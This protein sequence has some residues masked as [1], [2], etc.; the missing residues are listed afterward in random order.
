MLDVDLLILG[1]GL[2]GLS[3][4]ERLAAQPL[5]PR[6]CVLEAR[7][8]YTDD[9][10]WCSWRLGRGR[11]NHLA[12]SSWSRFCVRDGTRQALVDCADTPYQMIP[13]SVFYANAMEVLAGSS[14]VSLELGTAVAAEPVPCDDGWMVSLSDGRCLSA[15]YVVDTRPP[16]RRPQS[17]LW[18]SFLGDVVATDRDVFD[19]NT[20][21]LMD[22]DEQSSDGVQFLYVLPT[23]RREALVETT[24]FGAVPLDP[25]ALRAR[26]VQGLRA[27]VDG[28]GYRVQRSEHGVL[29]MGHEPLPAAA[30]VVKASLFHGGARASTGYAFARIQSWADTCAAVLLRGDGP[31]GPAPDPWLRRVMDEV[32]LRVLRA[33]PERGG[34]L[35]TRMFD[36]ADPARVIRFLSDRGSVRD[37]LSVVGSL[38]PAPFLRATWRALLRQPCRG[39]V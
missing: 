10:T 34:D 12:T 39:G 36:T 7:A 30:G 16:A 19:P 20:A 6:T 38:P 5:S 33:H 31:V 15:R 24:V 25:E 29:P 14:Q 11:Y 8:D 2:A 28:C 37:A 3:L 21:V 35:M 27:R 26:H 1:G 9:R 13:S 22:F 17:I 23:S 4:A 32:F 18:Q